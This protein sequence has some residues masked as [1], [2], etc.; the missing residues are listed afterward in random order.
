M[1]KGQGDAATEREAQKVKTLLLKNTFIDR[2]Q[3]IWNNLLW[4]DVNSLEEQY[5]NLFIS[6]KIKTIRKRTSY[7]KS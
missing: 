6:D 5:I 1:V 7:L 3:T 4:K 2:P